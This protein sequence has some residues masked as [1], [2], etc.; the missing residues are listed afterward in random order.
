MIKITYN[1]RFRFKYYPTPYSQDQEELFSQI[2][3]IIGTT[4]VRVLKCPWIITKFDIC[5]CCEMET[6]E[7]IFNLKELLK[8]KTQSQE[9]S[10]QEQM[11]LLI[12][13]K[14]ALMGWEDI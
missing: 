5:H 12:G 9:P 2:Q 7:E 13:N 4:V 11:E 8:S 10:Y 1:N 6:K 14:Y 3:D